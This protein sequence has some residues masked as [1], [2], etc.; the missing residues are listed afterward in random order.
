MK[1]FGL[2]SLV[3]ALVIVALLARNQLAASRQAVPL[4]ASQAASSAGVALPD[5]RPGDDARRLQDQV[6]DDLNKAMQER[7]SQVNQG[8]SEVDKP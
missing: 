6:R 8:L 2:V 3:V 5:A 7:A 4:A 1:V